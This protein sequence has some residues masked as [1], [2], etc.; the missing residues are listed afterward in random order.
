MH[1]SSDDIIP[2]TFVEM[3]FVEKVF[4]GNAFGEMGFGKKG[5][6][7]VAVRPLGYSHSLKAT[8]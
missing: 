8:F 3:V 4:R 2:G 5:F 7:D 6:G 1:D